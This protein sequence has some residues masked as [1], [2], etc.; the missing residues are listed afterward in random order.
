MTT[1]NKLRLLQPNDIIEYKH[2]FV[3]KTFI[4][5]EKE[6]VY[7]GSKKLENEVRAI[8][9]INEDNK[10]WLTITDRILESLTI[11]RLDLEELRNEKLNKLGI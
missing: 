7:K 6:V 4:F 5:V 1:Q 9:V 11:P 8:S 10:I 3:L 2:G